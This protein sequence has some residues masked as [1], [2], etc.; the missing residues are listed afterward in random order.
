MEKLIITKPDQSEYAP[1]YQKYIDLVKEEDILKVLST[2][3]D[4]FVS[5]MKRIPE[6]KGNYRYQPGKWSIKELIGHLIESERVFAFRALYFAR[7][8]VAQLPGYDQNLWVQE[9]NFDAEKLADLVN[10]FEIVRNT[11]IA[12]FHRF[13]N[14]N[15]LNH[16]VANNCQVSVR[17]I[18]YTMAGHVAHHIS[19]LN[20]LY[21]K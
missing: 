8:G 1:Y 19:I 13:S 18:A 3:N 21:A 5:L 10:E 6:E 2:Q 17:S 20:T 4:E 9:G 16:G 7:K 15:W 11:N 14:E 12:L